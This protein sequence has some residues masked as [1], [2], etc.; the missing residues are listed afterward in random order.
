MSKYTCVFANKLYQFRIGQFIL[1][2]V[3]PIYVHGVI[4]LIYDNDYVVNIN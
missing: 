4:T 3:E 1:N 2:H